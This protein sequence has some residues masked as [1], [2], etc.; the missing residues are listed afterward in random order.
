MLAWAKHENEINVY[1]YVYIL[2]YRTE[3]YIKIIKIISKHNEKIKNV[4]DFSIYKEKL[5]IFFW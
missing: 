4:I 3:N 2:I 1:L 5:H